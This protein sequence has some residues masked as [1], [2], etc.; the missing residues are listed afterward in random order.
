MYSRS[1]SADVRVAVNCRAQAHTFFIIN[2][3]IFTLPSQA[4]QWATRANTDMQQICVCACMRV[5]SG[6]P[7]QLYHTWLTRAPI[8]DE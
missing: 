6:E 7:W 8:L 4:S 3:I 1:S 2:N 5:M